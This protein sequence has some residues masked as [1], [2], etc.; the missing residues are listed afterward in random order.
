[1]S[2]IR[3]ALLQLGI[4][5]LRF[6]PDAENNNDMVTAAAVEFAGSPQQPGRSTRLSCYRE[7]HDHPVRSVLL[8]RLGDEEINSVG[9][10]TLPQVHTASDQSTWVLHPGLSDTLILEVASF[11]GAFRRYDV[12]GAIRIHLARLEGRARGRT[13]QAKKQWRIW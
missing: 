2:W 9:L 7:P 10:T 8:A 12:R 3:P 5:C 13:G 4:Y 1:M 6:L 11:N